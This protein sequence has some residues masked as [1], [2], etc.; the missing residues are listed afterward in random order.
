VTRRLLALGAAAVCAGAGGATAFAH[1]SASYWRPLYR[2]RYLVC[3]DAT[4]ATRVRCVGPNQARGPLLAALALGDLAPGK[5]HDAWIDPAREAAVDA[6][7]FHVQ[8][9]V[10]RLRPWLDLRLEPR[11]RGVYTMF[12][13]QELRTE[14]AFALAHLG[15]TASA[16]AIAQL[17][18]ELE[19][20]GSGTLWEDALAALAT[21]DPGRASRYAI[22]FVGRQSEFR[23][24]MPGGSSK[25]LALDYIAVSDAAA[26]EPV[27]GKLAAREEHGYDHAHCELMATRVRIDPVVHA[28]V[29][30][31]LLDHYSGTWLAGCAESVLRRFGGDPDDAAALVRHLGRDDAGMDFGVTNLAYERVLDL[32]VAMRGRHDAAASRAREVL[33]KGLAE[34]SGWPHVADPKSGNYSLH[35][36]ALHAAALAGLG[37]AAAA[38][39]LAAIVDDASDHSGVAWLA[40]LYELRLDLPGAVDRAAA[41]VA[42]GVT[43]ANEERSGALFGGVRA[44]VLDAYVA[45]APDDGRWAVLL[46][47]ADLRSEASERALDQLALHAPRGA[48]DAVTA[49]APSAKPAAVEHALLALTALGDACLPQ[50]EALADRGDAP[51]EVRGAALELVAALDSPRLCAHLARARADRV[52]HPAIER[53]E[54]MRQPR[55]DAPPPPPPPQSPQPARA[56][57]GETPVP[58]RIFHEGMR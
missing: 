42:R 13:K 26:A 43:Y 44:R 10:P 29:R 15:D 50:I 47:D 49:A 24:S 54:A 55:C 27:L 18:G 57:S 32:E 17:V 31:Q 2:E 35:F 9:A 19:V 34:R 56:G 11:D 45:R 23:M 8:D 7:Y 4:A 21:V 48:C 53:A 51:S 28:Q 12:E 52:W 3:T 6:A 38:A 30:K 16:P 20:D 37:D 25:L 22:D 39:R 46:L 1:H 5:N 36:V 58:T 41:L 40:S 14:A 33:R